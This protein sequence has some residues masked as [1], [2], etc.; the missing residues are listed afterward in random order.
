VEESAAIVDRLTAAGG[1]NAFA[2]GDPERDFGIATYFAHPEDP[3]HEVECHEDWGEC[4]LESGEMPMPA[5][6]SPSGVWPMQP[7]ESWDS[8][9]TVVDQRSGWEYDL[10]NVHSIGGGEIGTS[11]GGRTRITGDGLGSAAVAANYGSLAGLIR[12]QELAAGKINHALALNVP[13]THGQVYPATGSGRLCEDAGMPT[14]GAPAMGA[15]FQLRISDRKLQRFPGWQ[16]AILKA[17]KRYGAYVTDT[18]EVEEYWSLKFESRASYTSL[19]YKD[20]FEVLAR[21]RGL[22]RHDDN[23]NG[24]DEFMYQVSKGVDW[25]RL[26]VVR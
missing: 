6:A 8:H 24:D 10:W 1:I 11:W 5:E 14:P 9:L 16:R 23:A 26:R 25:S 3:E 20:P 15:R 21:K 18:T 4:E 12:P 22:P 13:C 19:G 2:A 17:L 7:D